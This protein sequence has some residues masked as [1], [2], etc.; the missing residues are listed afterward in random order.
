MSITSAPSRTISTARAAAASTDANCPPSLK[1][2]GVTLRTPTTIGR[3]M[4]MTRPAIRQ[5]VWMRA[6]I[7]G[8]VVSELVGL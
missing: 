4:T 8:T 2:S 7:G 1:L 6:A 3:S 5:L